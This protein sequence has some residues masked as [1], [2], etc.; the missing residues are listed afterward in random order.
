MKHG[1]VVVFPGTGY[2]CKER[3]F[4]ECTVKYTSFGYDIVSLDFSNIPYKEINTLEEAIE[5][6]KPVILEQLEGVIFEEYEDII[7]ISKSLGTVCA[8]WVE[9]Y[10]NVTPRQL[11]LTPLQETLETIKTASRIMGMVI[12]TKDKHLDYKLMESLCLERKIPYLICDDVG[13]N[14]KIDGDE[15]KTQ[16]ISMKI[17]KLCSTK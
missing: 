15:L 2:T 12:G 8:N 16:D 4:G 14:L 1:I 6:T 13:H 11:Y 7:F 3:L 17:A 9:E 5:K 10:F